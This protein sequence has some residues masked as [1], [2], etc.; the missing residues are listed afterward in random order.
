M[1]TATT[2]QTRNF[3]RTNEY[4]IQYVELY[5]KKRLSNKIMPN[6]HIDYNSYFCNTLYHYA[7]KEF[8]NKFKSIVELCNTGRRSIGIA[9][10]HLSE[11]KIKLN[12]FCFYDYVRYQYSLDM[13]N[14]GDWSISIHSSCLLDSEGTVY[15]PIGY[16]QCFEDE[17]NNLRE[18]IKYIGILSKERVDEFVLTYIEKKLF[19]PDGLFRNI[20][21]SKLC[22]KEKSKVYY[23]HACE[24]EKKELQRDYY[25][26]DERIYNWIK[27]HFKI[28]SN[29][30]IGMARTIKFVNSKG[31]Y[32]NLVVLN[33]FDYD[34]DGDGDIDEIESDLYSYLD[35]FPKNTV[36]V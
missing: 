34:Y 8:N 27:K 32:A 28:E 2:N 36:F 35:N 18:R 9:N 1:K 21:Y 22:S 16:Y 13:N 20:Q 29:E 24:Q 33:T 12:E 23:K 6:R 15:T 10:H 5:E 7:Q 25:E 30:Y 3:C 26:D 31:R 11:V 14:S 17:K 19:Y 4:F